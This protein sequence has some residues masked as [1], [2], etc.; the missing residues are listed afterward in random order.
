LACD[1]INQVGESASQLFHDALMRS[2]SMMVT[3]VACTIAKQAVALQS[4]AWRRQN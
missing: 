4:G 1:V 3:A 2:V